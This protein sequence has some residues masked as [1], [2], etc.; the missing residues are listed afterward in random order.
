M[1]I[2]VTPTSPAGTP[3]NWIVAGTPPTVT[4][5]ADVGSG[6]AVTAVPVA[7]AAPV[8]TAGDTGP[9]PVTY[10]DTNFPRPIVFTGT[11]KLFWSAKIPGAAAVIET[12]CVVT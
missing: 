7:G 10:T 3:I 9:V 5:V 12:V 1:L 11:R 8:G 4:A 6:N 2:C